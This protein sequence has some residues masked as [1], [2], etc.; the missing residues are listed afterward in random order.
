MT[1]QLSSAQHSP[2]NR[3]KWKT[4]TKLFPSHTLDSKLPPMNRFPLLPITV[5]YISM[6]TL[7]DESLLV[8]SPSPICKGEDSQ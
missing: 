2:S 6:R 7:P 1:A 8:H 5:E 4:S 3:A